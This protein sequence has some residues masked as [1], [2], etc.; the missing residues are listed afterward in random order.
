M[1]SAH[2]FDPS[3]EIA[4]HFAPMKWYLIVHAFFGGLALG[5]GAF[6]LSNRLRARY[7]PV[8]R[9]LGYIYVASVLISGHLVFR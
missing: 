4:Q 7:L 8:H 9:V 3:S 1:K 2:V 5:L 6:Q